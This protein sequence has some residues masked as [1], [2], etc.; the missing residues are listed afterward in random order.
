MNNNIRIKSALHLFTTVNLL[1]PHP[2]YNLYIIYIINT[3]QSY[4]FEIASALVITR[5]AYLKTN[6]NFKI[7]PIVM[8]KSHILLTS[9]K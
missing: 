8:E 1:L 2:A 7:E 6:T 3:K 9:E 5:L 4:S